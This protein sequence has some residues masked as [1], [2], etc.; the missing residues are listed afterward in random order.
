MEA[1]GLRFWHGDGHGVAIL[2]GGSGKAGAVRAGKGGVGGFIRLGLF[3]PW[4]FHPGHTANWKRVAS[5][6]SCR[7]R[8]GVMSAWE[9][10]PESRVFVAG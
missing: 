4:S 8:S 2:W 5:D 7:Q 10:N 3:Q 6:I 9:E 1:G